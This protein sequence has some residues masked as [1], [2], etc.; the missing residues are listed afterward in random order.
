MALVL[1]LVLLLL[2]LLLLAALAAL[3]VVMVMVVVVVVVVAAGPL[4]TR[5]PLCRCAGFALPLLLA[6]LPRLLVAAVV[7]VCCSLSLFRFVSCRF[8]VVSVVVCRLLSVSPAGAR[9]GTGSRRMREPRQRAGASL[10]AGGVGAWRFGAAA[11]SSLPH[12]SPHPPARKHNGRKQ[13]CTA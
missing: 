8:F 10:G 1:V 6:L 5:W 11:A 9:G 2:L 7:V 3:A 13:V 4:L 12:F